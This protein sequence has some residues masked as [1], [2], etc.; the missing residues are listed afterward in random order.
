[1]FYTINLAKN[2]L[3]KMLFDLIHI[4][5]QGVQ[6][7]FRLKLYTFETVEDAFRFN[8]QVRLKEEG[9]NNSVKNAT[10]AY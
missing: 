1:M 2:G 6:H 4:W 10:H 8:S 7:A 9:P 3:Y 5:N